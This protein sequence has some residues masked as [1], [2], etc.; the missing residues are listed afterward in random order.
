MKARL[1]ACTLALMGALAST[2]ANAQQR[3]SVE[4]ALVI[5]G[6]PV[7]AAV[8]TIAGKVYVE[9]DQIAKVLNL[10]VNRATGVIVVESAVNP[11]HVSMPPS[12]ASIS[13]SLTYYFNR[14]Y[15][16]RP[17]TGAKVYLL[18]AEKEFDVKD[19]DLVVAV[20]DKITIVRN[21]S[22][23]NEHTALLQTAA[24]GN[25]RFEFKSVPPGSYTLVAISSHTRGKASSEIMGK[26]LKRS[27]EIKSGASLDASHDFGMNYL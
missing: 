18:S 25:G 13:G 21:K 15:G 10:T 6:T 7:E 9:I 20:G 27:L 26:I 5:N 1:L 22:E 24:D 12:P 23:K 19:D 11:P 2:S 3:Q 8:R 4:P 16:N 17:D 14:N